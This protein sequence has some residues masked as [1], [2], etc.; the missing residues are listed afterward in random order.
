MTSSNRYMR[1]CKA[2]LCTVSTMAMMV[3]IFMFS[4]QNG[5][6]SGS[7]SGAVARLL[8]SVFYPGY[9][10]MGASDKALLIEQ[11]SW[12]V[13]KTAHATEYAI[14]AILSVATCWQWSSLVSESKGKSSIGSKRFAAAGIS[15]FV[16]AVA[17][18]M[19]DEVH[20]TFIDGRAGQFV[21]VLVDASGAAIGAVL[22]ALVIR[23]FC[24]RRR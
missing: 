14:L 15:G 20:Q 13:R 7:L 19:S 10:L 4:A 17:Y 23:S 24:K 2:F 12:P 21:D 11:M 16:L 9:D 22:C 8:A 1:I 5:A 3:V 18:A 6:E